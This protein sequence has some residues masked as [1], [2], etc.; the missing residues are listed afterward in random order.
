VATAVCDE[1]AGQ[2]H[3]VMRSSKREENFIWQ[4]I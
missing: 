3:D 1:G 4:I 2:Q